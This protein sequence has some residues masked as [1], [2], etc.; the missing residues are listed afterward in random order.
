MGSPE[1]ALYKSS[2]GKIYVRDLLARSLQQISMQCLRTRSPQEVPRQDLIRSLYP[3]FIKVLLARSVSEISA[4]AL[5]K[6][7]LGKIS[8][9]VQDV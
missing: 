7:S 3:I 6:N 1:Q 4:Q 5:Y 2:L 8:T 9:D